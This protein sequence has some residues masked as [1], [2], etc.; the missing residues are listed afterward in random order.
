MSG[1]PPSFSELNVSLLLK[2]R[3]NLLLSNCKRKARLIIQ[4]GGET[5]LSF[6]NVAYR[7]LVTWSS[8]TWRLLSGDVAQHDFVVCL[9]RLDGQRGFVQIGI[10]AVERDLKRQGGQVGIAGR[11]C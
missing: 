10:G 6:T 2:M 4:G 9:H 11:R 7:S 3:V 5:L 1:L 8:A